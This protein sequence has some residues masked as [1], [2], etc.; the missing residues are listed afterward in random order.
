M[1]V[2]VVVVLMTCNGV[3]PA[4]THG[5]CLGRFLQLSK[6]LL[7]QA[8]GFLFQ[9]LQEEALCFGCFGG[10]LIWKIQTNLQ[11]SWCG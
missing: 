7:L 9:L 5:V 11:C 3:S 1:V 4:Q 6:V 10:C 2:V 8:E